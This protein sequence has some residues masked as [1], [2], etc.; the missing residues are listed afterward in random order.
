MLGHDARIDYGPQA[1][2]KWEEQGVRTL[3]GDASDH[4]LLSS[5]PLAATALAVSTLPSADENLPL[6]HGLQEEGY[7]GQIADL[8][9]E[10]AVLAPTEL[11]E[12]LGEKQYR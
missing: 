2:R 6:L 11:I 8:V 10:P 5:I 9:V 4:H 7:R 3:L 1:T 12:L